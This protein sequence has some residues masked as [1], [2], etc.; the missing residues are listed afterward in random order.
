MKRFGCWQ[1][2]SAQLIRATAQKGPKDTAWAPKRPVQS[3]LPRTS[4]CTIHPF[5]TNVLVLAWFQLLNMLVHQSFQL[6][7]AG[8][9]PAGI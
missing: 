1:C 8:R 9:N 6:F 4:G 7:K 5:I 3:R 2:G